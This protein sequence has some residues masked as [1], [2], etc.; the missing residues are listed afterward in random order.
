MT[1]STRL[2]NGLSKYSVAAALTFALS[3]CSA[4]MEKTPHTDSSAT[5]SLSRLD[6]VTSPGKRID[7]EWTVHTDGVHGALI[8]MRSSDVRTA[9]GL[10]PS[11]SASKEECEYLDAG[12]LPVKLFFM[13]HSD[14][15]V[16]IDVR[17]S[18][19]A[20]AEGARIGDT[21]GRIRTIYG[22][23]VQV[24][25]HKYTGPEGHYLIVAP[26][27]GRNRMIVFE[28]DGDHVTTYRVGREP[29]VRYVEGCS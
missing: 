22:E 12:V 10:A 17:D 21:E 23:K 20:T 7:A 19:V 6:S 11:S 25:P 4:E 15:L 3:S 24:E 27:G 16:R 9:I 28:T 8:G 5:E 1:N 13:L 18:T 14:T 2:P 29:E 26:T